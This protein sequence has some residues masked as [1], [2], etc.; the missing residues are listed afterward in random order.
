MK[1]VIV[2][3][4]AFLSGCALLA[5]QRQQEALRLF[6]NCMGAVYCNYDHVRQVVA[7]S[8]YPHMDLIDL[9][10]AHRKA[11]AL[12][13][14]KNELTHEEANVQLAELRA[15]IASEE[16][17]RN[18]AVYQAQLQAQQNFQNSLNMLN[19]NLQQQQNR[20]ALMMQ[21]QSPVLC[22]NLGPGLAQCY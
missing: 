3:I 15:R 16:Q 7:E 5:A 21:Q 4:A 13:L 1:N 2:L 11:L 9:A 22:Q 8:G 12:R 10:F 19:Y 20:D 6:G 14:A 18:A 17:R